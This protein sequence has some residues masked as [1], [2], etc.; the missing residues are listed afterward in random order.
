MPQLADACAAGDVA[1]VRRLLAVGN[2][3]KNE[4]S[5]AGAP[6]TVLAAAP[7]RRRVR[8]REG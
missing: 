2:R 6:T 8:C 4:K 7:R 5:S 1:A 3:S